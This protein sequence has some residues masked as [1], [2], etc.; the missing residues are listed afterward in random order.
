GPVS[1]TFTALLKACAATLDADLGRQI[2][3]QTITIGG[4]ASDLYVGNTMID[5][6]VKCGFL[7]CGRK[8]FDEMPDRDVISWTSLIVG[9]ARRGDMDLAGG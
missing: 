1:F 4:F 8:V 9:Y 3:G 7:D 2:H 5:M 6:Y